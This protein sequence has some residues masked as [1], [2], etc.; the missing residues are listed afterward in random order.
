MLF[1]LRGAGRRTTVKVVYVLLAV[2]MGGGLILFG[3]G[4]SV[5]GGLI[6][7]ITQQDSTSSTGNEEFQRRAAAAQ[8]KAAA[9]PKDAAAWAEAAR[10]RYQLALSG[11]NFDQNTGEFSAAGKAQLQIAARDWEKHVALKPNQPNDNV[12]GIMVNVYAQ[13]LNEPAKAVA[14]QEIVAEARPKPKTYANLAVLAYQAGQTRKGDLAR[15]KAL[16]LA[17]PAD[18]ETLKSDLDQAKQQALASQIQNAT[19]TPTPTPKKK[20]KKSS[21]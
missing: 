17:D 8:Q 20:D 21:G 4:G 5:S 1:D 15:Q 16:E 9:N 11:D 14:A 6:D 18:R 7:A 13:G 2:L 3:I 10:T 12:A 19:P